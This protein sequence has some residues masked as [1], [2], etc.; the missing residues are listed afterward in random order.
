[1]STR[2][3]VFI[4]IRKEDWE[5]FAKLH[6]ENPFVKDVEIKSYKNTDIVNVY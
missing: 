2:S 4:T 3:D 6:K 5:K 1:M